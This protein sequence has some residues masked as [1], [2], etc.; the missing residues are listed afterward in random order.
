[1]NTSNLNN[2]LMECPKCGRRALVERRS[3]L[4]QC[5]GCDFKRDLAKSDSKSGS[6]SSSNSSSNNEL[7]WLLL[8]TTII[9]LLV[10][11]GPTFNASRQRVVPQ[12][13]VPQNTG[14]QPVVPQPIAPQPI[15]YPVRG[16]N[17]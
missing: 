13:G 12:N 1:M 4:Y 17:P 11:N 15:I 14:V 10:T 7:S 2:L 16:G 6:S 8:V 3:G 5:V 9:I